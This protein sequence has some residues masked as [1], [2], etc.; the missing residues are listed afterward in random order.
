MIH[1][2]AKTTWIIYQLLRLFIYQPSEDNDN[3]LDA[4]LHLG[5]YKHQNYLV[6]VRA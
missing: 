3:K 1:D 2:L 5:Q 6:L 4:T